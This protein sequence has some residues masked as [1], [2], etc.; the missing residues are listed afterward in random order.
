MNRYVSY[1]KR[2][3][4]SIVVFD[5]YRD[6]PYTK[7]VTHRR[8]GNGHKG[9]KVSLTAS[10]VV[11][12]K[13]KTFL[14][15]KDNKQM[16]IDMLGERVEQCGNQEMGA[17]GDV[18]LLIAKT[19]VEATNKSDTVL[20]GEGQWHLLSTTVVLENQKSTPAE[21]LPQKKRI[22]FVSTKANQHILSIPSGFQDF[23]KRLQLTKLLLT[24]KFFHLFPQRQHIT[25]SVSSIKFKNGKNTNWILLN[26]AG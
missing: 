1:I 14:K 26:G 24:L 17:S 13:K 23:S 12:V 22:W 10:M 18:Y 3:G 4:Q 15:N 11:C 20:V 21:T 2:Y 9:R 16:F 7:D 8:R 19:A 6:D 25:T 5:G